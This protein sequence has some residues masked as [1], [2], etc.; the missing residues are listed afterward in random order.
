VER[1]NVPK[2]DDKKTHD[3]SDVNEIE[4]ALDFDEGGG[5]EIITGFATAIA[6]VGSVFTV[7]PI[8]SDADDMAKQIFP[9]GG[10]NDEQDA[11]RHAY[12]SY[13]LA[14]EVGG[15]VAKIWGDAHERSDP[16]PAGER[17]MDLY[18]NHVGRTLQANSKGTKAAAHGPVFVVL[19]ALTTGAL[20]TRPL[21]TQ[22]NTTAGKYQ[23]YV[24]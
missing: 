5:G 18:N 1:K 7:W 23:H 10:H 24:K 6:G 11:F 9:S 20:M 17:V 13:R 12:F 3:D 22:N 8:K 19:N 21:P 4:K 15:R 2:P 16:N 14:E